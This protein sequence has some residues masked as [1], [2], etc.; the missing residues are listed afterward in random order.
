MGDPKRN[1]GSDHAVRSQW[2]EHD[3][4]HSAWR[5]VHT[6]AASIG[7]KVRQA[8]LVGMRVMRANLDGS[9][10]KLSWIR[11]RA[12]RGRRIR[13]NG[14]SALRWTLRAASSIGRRRV[15]TTRVWVEFFGPTSKFRQ[16][17]RARTGWDI[18]LLYDN[19]PEPIDLDLDPVHQTL[20]WTDRGDPPRGN[21]VNRAPMNPEAE[22]GKEPEILF[23]H[24]MEGIGLALDLKGGRM[25][26][27]DLGGSVP[28]AES[29]WVEPEDVAVC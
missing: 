23:A 18:E 26:I 11:A 15:A 24:L 3:H 9:Q 19:L 4:H 22:N 1:D 16:V 7:E 21:T 5:H 17:S 29:R 28:S 25:F 20:Y 2:Q 12:I 10:L 8:L 6:E 14:V 13:G 27:T